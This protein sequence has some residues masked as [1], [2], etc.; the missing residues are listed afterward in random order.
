M[1]RDKQIEEIAIEL[2]VDACKK[3]GCINCAVNSD[4]IW[5]YKATRLYNLDY[6][7]ASDVAEEIIKDLESSIDSLLIVFK[8]ERTKEDVI[9][10]PL[11]EYLSGKIDAY[12]STKFRLAELKKKYTEAKK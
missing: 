2:G 3:T 5:L 9:D 8:E 10:T 1:S 4:C 11:A 7:K 6:R 12:A